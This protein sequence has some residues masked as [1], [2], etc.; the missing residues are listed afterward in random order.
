ML[1]GERILLSAIGRALL[2]DFAV[3]TTITLFY[4]M[5]FLVFVLCTFTLLQ[6]GLASRSTQVLFV[7]TL[8]SFFLFTLRWSF[9]IAPLAIDIRGTF[10]DSAGKLNRATFQRL[11]EATRSIGLIEAS[12]AQFLIAISDGVVIWRAWVLYPQQMLIM[13]GP[14]MFFVGTIGTSFANVLINSNPKA[15]PGIPN[16]AA[17]ITL[18][19]SLVLSLV[20]NVVSTLL[21][22]HKLR[23]YRRFNRAIGV[24]QKAVSPV[25][26]IMLILIESGVAFGAIQV[27]NLIL[28]L[29]PQSS[30]SPVS[31]VTHITLAVLVASTAI[32]PSIVIL[33]VKTQRSVVQTFEFSTETKNLKAADVEQASKL[34][35]PNSDSVNA[36]S[37]YF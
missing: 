37:N 32:Y 4:G 1:R 23:S 30:G 35:S 31:L 36:H 27:L 8:A 25:Q 7:T 10:V 13:V 33:L 14:C 18:L 15:S 9:A 2:G 16:A 22:L 29:V 20:T 28:E 34:A 5:G 3:V 21:I 17:E 24:T 26:K 6:R 11:D 12:A 19:S